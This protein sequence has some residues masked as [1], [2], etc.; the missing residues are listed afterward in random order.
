LIVYAV[1]IE[2]VLPGL[3]LGLPLIGL[4]LVLAVVVG[5][6]VVNLWSALRRARPS[7]RWFGFG[8]LV[9]VGVYQAG[10]GYWQTTLDFPNAIS[11]EDRAR[12]QA[13]CRQELPWLLAFSAL[14][15]VA[16]PLLFLPP[17][18]RFL[19]AQET[20]GPNEQLQ[21]TGPA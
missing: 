21:P 2:V 14:N 13:S 19:R 8:L 1:F 9:L 10:F 18:G 15:M 6:T 16:A 11:P 12:M 4:W 7:F 5:A 17:V 20:S 3:P